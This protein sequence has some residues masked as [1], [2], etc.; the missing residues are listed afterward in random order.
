M[1]T[2]QHSE[3]LAIKFGRL[4]ERC[5]KSTMYA[6]IEMGIELALLEIISTYLIH[7]M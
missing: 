4:M 5:S 6:C 7:A 3:V 1:A 2:D